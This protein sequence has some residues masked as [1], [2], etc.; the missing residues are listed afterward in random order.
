MK[1]FL[2]FHTESNEDIPGILKTVIEQ[3]DT[4]EKELKE[5]KSQV[6]RETKTAA[7]RSIYT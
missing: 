4:S 5:L 1:H 3:L 2:K 6:E 7:C